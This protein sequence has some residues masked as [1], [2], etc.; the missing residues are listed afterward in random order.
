M[1]QW[2]FTALCSDCERNHDLYQ[3]QRATVSKRHQLVDV[4]GFSRFL[5]LLPM[6]DS[7]VR[8]FRM[9]Q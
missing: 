6:H 5:P 8:N 2:R 9:E 3:K 7:Q 4:R 1:K